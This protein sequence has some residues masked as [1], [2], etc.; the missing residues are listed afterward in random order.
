MKPHEKSLKI[1][2]INLEELKR[3]KEENFEER[4]RFIDQYAEWVMKTP[5]RKWSSEQKKLME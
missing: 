1:P 4:L 3:L 2:K 5:N